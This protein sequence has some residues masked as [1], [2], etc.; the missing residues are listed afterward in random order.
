VFLGFVLAAGTVIHMNFSNFVPTAHRLLLMIPLVVGLWLF[1]VQEEGLKR[2]VA[3]DA[4]PWAGLV[5]GLVGKLVIVLTWLGAAAL[6]NPQPFLPLTMPV[7]AP[8]MFLLELMS[9]LLNRW[10]YP[11]T[12]AATFTSL[13]MVWSV[14]VTFPLV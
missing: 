1:F 9:Y 12:A 10:R 8:V 2:A 11:A 13:V 4:G 14:A 7:I 5:V 6:P 3:N